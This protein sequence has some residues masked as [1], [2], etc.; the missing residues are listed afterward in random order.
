MR[1]P[2][3]KFLDPL[4]ETLLLFNLALF[5]KSRH[6][7]WSYIKFYKRHLNVLPADNLSRVVEPNWIV[8]QLFVF[9][10]P[11]GQQWVPLFGL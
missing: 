8:R 5:D 7:R 1:L 4:P 9:V 6:L 10:F 11:F 3:L 2:Y